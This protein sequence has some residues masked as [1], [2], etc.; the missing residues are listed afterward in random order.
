MGGYANIQRL[1]ADFPD[2][3]ETGATLEENAK[4]K[5]H[6]IYERFKLPTIADDTGLV[7]AVLGGAPGVFTARYAGDAAS[8]E[9]N[10]RKLLAEL[11]DKPDRSAS[12]ITVLC[13]MDSQGKGHLFRGEVKGTIAPEPRGA[14]GFGYDPVFIPNEGNGR[15]FAEMSAEEKNSLSHRARA[16]HEFI[17]NIK[18]SA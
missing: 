14:N 9:D 15:T 17:E 2:I 11:K 8:Y 1:P 4:L 5:A 13:Y 3:A 7:V 16:I 6:E 18:F 12:F 10:Y